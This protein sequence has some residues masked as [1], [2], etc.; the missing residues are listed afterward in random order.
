MRRIIAKT[1][2]DTENSKLI[3]KYTEGTYGDPAGFE[4]TLYETPT[5]KFFFYMNGGE[6]SPYK[7]EKIRRVSK[8]NAQKFLE[9]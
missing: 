5:G 4:K 3:K 1:E 2:Y 9:E 8:I 7:T 6:L